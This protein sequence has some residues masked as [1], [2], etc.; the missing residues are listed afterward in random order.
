VVL[1]P[2]K[3]IWLASGQLCS[4]LLKATLPEWL[5]FY[6]QTHGPLNPQTHQLLLAISAAQIDRL[7][8]PVRRR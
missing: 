7:L 2:L 6:E 3:T 8:R 5:G 1:S 4:K